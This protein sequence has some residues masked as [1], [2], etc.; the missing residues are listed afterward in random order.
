MRVLC[1]YVY[2]YVYMCVYVYICVY[3]CEYVVYICVYMYRFSCIRRPPPPHHL[4][5]PPPRPRLGVFQMVHR[6]RGFRDHLGGFG[7]SFEVIWTQKLISK[8]RNRRFRGHLISFGVNF[9]IIRT[10]KLT[11][12]TLRIT[13]EVSG[14]TRLAM[15]PTKYKFW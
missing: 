6:S 12:E 10:Q 4:A 7:V 15:K 11:S 14:S 2:M 9:E 8:M 5:S 13:W 1:I 3:M